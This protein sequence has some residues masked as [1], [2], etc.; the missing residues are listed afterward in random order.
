MPQSLERIFNPSQRTLDHLVEPDMPGTPAEKQWVRDQIVEIGI[1]RLENLALTAAAAREISYSPYSH[2]KVGAA[3]LDINGNEHGGQNIE[4]VTY[5]EGTHAE[6]MCVKKAV[7]D[8]AVQEMG[9]KFVKAVAV[10][11]KGNTAP[12]GRCRQII[13]ELADNAL[14]V[15]ADEKGKIR[16]VTSL[17]ILLPY[18]FTP[19]DLG[20]K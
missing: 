20:I 7:S 15:V 6:E 8:H 13:A 10:S 16:S 3:I 18:A 5:S 14:I 4:I 2:Y 19:K 1:P 17:L 11:H 12:C 9:R